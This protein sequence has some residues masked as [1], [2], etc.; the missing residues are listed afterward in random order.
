MKTQ[1]EIEEKR[2]LYLQLAKAAAKHGFENQ[3]A[4]MI[5]RYAALSWVLGEKE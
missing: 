3:E 4:A 5:E 2:D 1:K